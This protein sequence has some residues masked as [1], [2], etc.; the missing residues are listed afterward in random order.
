M[1]I[2]SQA[3]KFTKPRNGKEDSFNIA[4]AYLNFLN[5]TLSSPAKS[6]YTSGSL[7]N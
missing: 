3:F 7:G 5:W 4:K 6:T 2:I 1:R